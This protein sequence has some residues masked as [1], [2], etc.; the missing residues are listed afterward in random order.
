MNAT[1]TQF[2]ALSVVI[3][4][5]FIGLIQTPKRHIAI[6]ARSNRR[7]LRRGVDALV[8]NGYGDLHCVAGARKLWI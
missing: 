4:D 7:I 8:L 5:A 3:V 1:L 2:E 6:D